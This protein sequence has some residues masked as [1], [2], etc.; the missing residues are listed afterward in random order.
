LASISTRGSERWLNLG[1][2]ASSLATALR[3]CERMRLSGTGRV[4]HALVSTR[5]VTLLSTLVRPLT[6][7]A[8]EY[9]VVVAGCTSFEPDLATGV[10]L[11]L[12]PT[13]QPEGTVTPQRSVA[14]PPNGGTVVGVAVNEPTLT[15]ARHSNVSLSSGS[16][17]MGMRSG[18]E[19]RGCAMS[20]PP[21]AGRCA[22]PGPWHNACRCGVRA[23][24][25]SSSPPWGALRRGCR[26]PSPT[27]G[28]PLLAT[29]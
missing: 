6:T 26:S 28:N 10:P 24:S 27:V 2:A 19:L 8:S 9:D 1:S 16:G 20:I 4:T 21:C 25:V 5:T 23:W 11:S 18:L 3:T 7:A 29:C 22:R 14:G 13:A 12:R 15:L 17:S